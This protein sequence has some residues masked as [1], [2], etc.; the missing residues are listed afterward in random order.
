VNIDI[1]VVGAPNSTGV[2]ELLG[3]LGQ[4][5]L[6]DTNCTILVVDRQRLL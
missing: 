6:D 1:V 3:P 2:G 5:A 4:T